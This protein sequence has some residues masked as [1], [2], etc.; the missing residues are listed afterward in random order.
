LAK[1]KKIINGGWESRIENE[2]ETGWTRSP[3]PPPLGVGR[4]EGRKFGRVRG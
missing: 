4:K 3:T 1:G 2:K